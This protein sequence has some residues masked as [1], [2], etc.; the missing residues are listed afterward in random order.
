[1]GIEN[2]AIEDDMKKSYMDYAMSV[3]VSRALPDVRDGLKPVHRRILYSMYELGNTHS[4]AYKKSARIVGEVLG[5]YHPHGDAAI[6]DSLVRMAQPFSL[7]NMLVDGQGNFGSIDGDS[8]AAMRYTECRMRGIAEE[9]I[10]DIEKETVEWSPNFDGTLKEPI[11]LPSRVPN[12]LINGSSGIAVG[13]A[14]NIPPHNLI[15]VA[16]AIIAAI[17]GADEEALLAIVQGPD[18]PTGGY[19]VG[20]RGILSAYKSGRGIIRVRAR[21]QTKERE[22]I[23]TEIPYQVNKTSLIQQ[24][25]ECVKDKK[26][27]GISGLHDRSDKD[28]LNVNIELKR[29]EDP[30]IVLRQLYAHTD[31]EKSFGIINLALVDGKP[32]QL[33]LYE[34]IREFIEFRKEIITRRSRFELEKAKARLHILE[35][36][37]IALENI[38]AIVKMVKAASNAESARAALSETY[39]LSEKQALAILDMKLQKLTNMERDGIEGEKRER[40]GEIRGLLELLGDERK[41]LD[42]IKAETE[43]VKAKFGDARKTEILE[44]EEDGDIESLIP[45]EKV[46]VTFSKR[47]Y[48]KRVPL[49]EYKKQRRGGLGVIAA[50][51]VEDDFIVDVIVTTNHKYMLFFTDAGRVH[52]LKTYRIPESGRYSKGKPIVNLLELDN[53]NVTA[54]VSVDEFGDDEHL[55]MATANGTITKTMLSAFS[56]PRKGGIIAITLREGD[57]LID[58]K[59][60]DGE[61]SLLL[62]TLDGH[63]VRFNEKD[64]RQTGRGSM[65]VRGIRLR[66]GDAVVG[67]AV[68]DKPHI[69]TITENGYGKRTEVGEYRIQARGGQG[70]INIKASGR[71]GK[72]V[73]IKS[74]DDYDEIIVV[75]SRGRIVRMGALGIPVIGRNTMGVRIAKLKEGE[76]VSSFTVMKPEEKEDSGGEEDAQE[77]LG[78]GGGGEEGG[79]SGISGE[80]DVGE[81]EGNEGEEYGGEDA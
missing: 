4:K 59:K 70:I 54:W 27:E 16:D 24:I 58:V 57:S 79:A 51:T 20:R 71:N 74:T 25:V 53:E 45:D 11:V 32:R 76:K 63:S 38:D 41:I 43:E 26:I 61:Q 15:E 77:P 8:A 13:M 40:E 1:M 62:G 39:G 78:R 22:I 19:I 69:L 50:E 6:Y 42:V 34:M 60:T 10:R 21:A 18:F 46:V 30:E 3:I 31:L 65:G 67:L 55:V 7:R 23:V 48:I 36:L 2:I 72:V 33:T 64:V 80:G 73:G 68:C 75:S 66:K 52:W 17:E 81:A 44:D 5:K 56:R 35:G 29:G 14:T 12:L 28:G 47:G 37:V 9:M 49:E